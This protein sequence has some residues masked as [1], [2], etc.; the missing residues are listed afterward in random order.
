MV[1]ATKDPC[2]DN[3]GSPCATTTTPCATTTTPCPTTWAPCPTTTTPCPTTTTPCAT[4]TVKKP[5]AKKDPCDTK[6]MGK[7]ASETA[8]GLANAA[9]TPS[10]GGSNFGWQWSLVLFAG[11]LCSAAT[12]VRVLVVLRTGAKRTDRRNSAYEAIA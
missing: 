1:N 4:T 10:G 7:Y 11:V 3:K 12:L 6:F 8:N 9:E 2:V 5:C